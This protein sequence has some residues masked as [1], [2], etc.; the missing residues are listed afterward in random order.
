[1]QCVVELVV[2]LQ[3]GTCKERNTDS[4]SNGKINLSKRYIQLV[5]PF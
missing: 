4:I 2:K 3:Y 5:K 1:M